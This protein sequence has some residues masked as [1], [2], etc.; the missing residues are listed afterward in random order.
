MTEKILHKL[1][2]LEEF[3]KKNANIILEREKMIAEIDHLIF[4]DNCLK[5]HL[6]SCEPEYCGFRYTGECKYL[7]ERSKLLSIKDSF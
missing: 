1:K 4:K 5:A 3:N 7:D 2:E 6:N